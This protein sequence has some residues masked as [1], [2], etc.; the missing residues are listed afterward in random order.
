MVTLCLAG[1]GQERALL[2]K[3]AKRPTSVCRAMREI[4]VENCAK[5]L[6]IGHVFVKVQ[7]ELL[8]TGPDFEMMAM[9][10]VLLHYMAR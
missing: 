1:K 10:K 3:L 6:F 9:Y 7:R 8:D 4:V 2:V 5:A